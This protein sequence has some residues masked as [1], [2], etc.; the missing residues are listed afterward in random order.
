MF[1]EV[2]AN[3]K[4]PQNFDTLIGQEFAVSTLKNAISTGKIA[5]AYLF[6]GPRGVGK[7]SAARI[8]AKAL[9]CMEGPTPEPCGVCSNCVAIQKASSMDV[10]EI[11]GASNTSVNDIRQIK[12]EVLFAPSSSTYKIYIID[13]VHMLSNSAFNALLKTVEEPPPYVVFIFATTEIHKVPAT[14][15]SRCQ[16]FNFRLITTERIASQL[17]SVCDENGIKADDEALFWVAKEGNGSMRDAYTLFD[18]VLSFSGDYINYQKISQELGIVGLDTINNFA[19]KILA[20]DR[21]AAFEEAGNILLA[22]IAIEQFIIDLAEYFRNILFIKSGITARNVL[23]YSADRFS[24]RVVDE[25][26]EYQLEEAVSIILT[27]YKSIKFSLNQRYEFE[28]LISKLCSIRDKLTNQMLVAQIKELRETIF[29]GGPVETHQPTQD[30]VPEQ[31]PRVSQSTREPEPEKTFSLKA[32]FE[33]ELKKKTLK[34]DIFAQS[35]AEPTPKEVVSDPP[36]QQVDY[37]SSSESEL[38]AENRVD[39]VNFEKKSYSSDEILGRLVEEFKLKQ[40]VLSAALDQ[41]VSSRMEDNELKLLFNS[42]YSAEKVENDFFLIREKIKELFGIACSVS[43][44]INQ[45]NS[46]K[47]KSEDGDPFDSSIKMIKELFRGEVLE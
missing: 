12:D 44:A 23:G 39:Y 9:N 46:A 41:V 11:D 29:S 13:E 40:T 36:P 35:Q 19:E 32:A 21:K 33:Q 20:G 15:R 47:L 18:Q 1:Y 3:R 28:L 42:A 30:R 43:V 27:A 8:M 26:A 10:I 25:L 45:T 22:G 5:H 4:R 17:K 34:S 37:S 14:I 31:P 7:T 38:E 24:Q 6:A 2:T 16:Q